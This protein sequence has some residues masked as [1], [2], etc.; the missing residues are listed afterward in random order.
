MRALSSQW[1]SQSEPDGVMSICT[2]KRVIFM[3]ISIIFVYLYIYRNLLN[4]GSYIHIPEYHID[5]EY[6]IAIQN[7]CFGVE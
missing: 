2:Y 3:Y 6:C 4:L 5:I 1:S 7:I